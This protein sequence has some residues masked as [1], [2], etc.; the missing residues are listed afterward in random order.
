MT[1]AHW[2]ELDSLMT[3]QSLDAAP[4]GT[5]ERRRFAIIAATAVA[6]LVLAAVLRIAATAEFD[7]PL[8][9]S[10][11]WAGRSLWL[12]HFMEVL[13]RFNAPKG[14][15]LFAL[16]F[17]AF[18]ANR[19]PLARWRLVLGCCVASLA[20]AASRLI[21]IFMPDLPRPLFDPSLHFHAPIDAD[22]TALRDW[23]S[24][25]SD[26]AALLCGVAIAVFL[27]DRRFGVIA[28]VLFALSAFARI[29]DGLHFTTDIVGGALLSAAAVGA[30]WS[31]DL[32]PLTARGDVIERHRAILTGL[33]FFVAAQAASLFDEARE[34]AVLLKHWLQ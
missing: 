29:Y 7:Y 33:A 21:Q 3:I 27:T 19:A 4:G 20:A 17:A 16:A 5:G 9:R 14:V 34:A 28:L 26:N 13:G 18:A 22:P 30:V 31:A 25:P 32:T 6:G 10:M 23:S 11:N 1:F 15:A 8:I 24:F 2:W 12:D